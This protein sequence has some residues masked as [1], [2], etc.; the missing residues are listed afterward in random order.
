MRWAIAVTMLAALVSAGPARAQATAPQERINT[1]LTRA[2]QV[3]LP[4][5]LLESKIAE[6]RAKGKSQEIIAAAI[7]RR[8]SALERASQALRGDA[9]AVASLAVGADAIEAGISEA[10]LRALAESAPRDRR[11]VAIAALTELVNRGLASE[12]ALSRVQD[13]LK[14][15][16]DALSN[17]PGES[18]GRGNGRSDSQQRG[19]SGSGGNSSSGKGGGGGSGKGGGAPVGADSGPPAAVPGPG[20]PSQAGRPDNSGKGSGG[21]GNSGGNPGRGNSGG[22]NPGGG[23]GGGGN[24]GRG[25]Q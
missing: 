24:P 17:L 21:G 14:R 9:D 12:T 25:G 22:G 16:P 2:K 13:A 8:L 23:G 7:E 15:G 10:V 5:A 6:G 19:N 18:S 11:N 1:A 3:G 4:I 20:Q